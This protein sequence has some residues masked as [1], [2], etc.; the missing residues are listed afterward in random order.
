MQD[1]RWTVTDKLTQYK[2]II[3]LF[4]KCFV[5]FY[6]RLD[7]KNSILARDCKVHQYDKSIKRKKQKLLLKKLQRDVARSKKELDNAIK[8]DQQ[9]IR[10]ALAAEKPLQQAF[11]GLSPTVNI[12]II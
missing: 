1:N 5:L 12:C 3:N 2:G 8:G 4:S 7:L 10:N 9:N 11:Q 6:F